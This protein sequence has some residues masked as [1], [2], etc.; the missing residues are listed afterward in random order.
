MVRSCGPSRTGRRASRAHL[1]A[2][3]RSGSGG[4]RLAVERFLDSEHQGE[5]VVRGLVEHT[6]DEECGR[7]ADTT[8]CAARQV[9]T[10][11][12]VEGALVHVG[13]PTVGVRYRARRIAHQRAAR[14]VG[15]VLEQH[16]VH[17]PEGTLG[18]GSFRGLRSQL[19]VWVQLPKREVA[20][21]EA[22]L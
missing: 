17:C 1:D 18:A 20:K 9:L 14:E 10:D 19:G 16:V 11:A 21:Y 7:A 4:E 6:V 12:G 2:R 3:R 15:L 8:A 22:Q 5:L 13:Y